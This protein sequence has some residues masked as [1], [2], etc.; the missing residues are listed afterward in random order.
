MSRD[1]VPWNRV[2]H[3]FQAALDCPPEERTRSRTGRLVERMGRAYDSLDRGYHRVLAVAL[4][5]PWKT[6]GVAAAVFLASLSAATVMGTEFQKMIAGRQ[7][8]ADTAKTIQAEWT[9]FDSTI[10]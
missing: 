6:L 4:N 5:N 2:K 3:V 10:K 9:K 1:E 7:S 8:P